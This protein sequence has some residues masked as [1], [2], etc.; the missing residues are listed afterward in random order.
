MS[1]PKDDPDT[2]NGWGQ[3]AETKTNA[4]LDALTKALMPPDETSARRL[5]RTPMDYALEHAEYLAIAA[6][7]FMEDVN[8][9]DAATMA[10][11]EDD[12]DTTRQS[13][14]E[15]FD[16]ALEARSEGLSTLRSRVYEFRKRAERAKSSPVEPEPDK[17]SSEWCVHLTTFDECPYGCTLIAPPEASIMKAQ[18]RSPRRVEPAG[19]YTNEAPAHPP[20]LPERFNSTSTPEKA[21]CALCAEGMNS[22]ADPATG[23][24]MHARNGVVTVCTAQNGDERQ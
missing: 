1:R 15:A 17:T 7:G 10:I 4:A 5:Q 19:A 16:R 24:R 13:L 22:F 3:W 8:N 11:E 6:E 9:L 18:A 2:E 23:N 21:G 14:H 12:S 20:I